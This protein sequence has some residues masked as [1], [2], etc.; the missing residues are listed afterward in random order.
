MQGLAGIIYPDIFQV[1]N[2]IQSMLRTQRHRSLKDQE[3]F[4]HKN[5][6]IGLCGGKIVSNEKK[7]IFSGIDGTITNSLEIQL[8]LR[9]KGI[10]LNDTS[11]A[12]IVLKSYEC[13][14]VK[15]FDKLDGDFA[16]MI[17]DT[18]E[19]RLILARDRIGKKPLYWFQNQNS[20]M[21][22]SELKALL[23][24]GLVP[25]TPAFD[26]LASY[27]YF[28]YIPQD[29]SPIEGVSKLLPAHYLQFE[30]NG[31]KSIH[32][33]WSY[34][35][36]FEKT[37]TE[38]TEDILYNL[39]ALL[40]ES[41]KKNMTTADRMGCFIS[42][43][44]G[45]AT[46]A[47][48]MKQLA[49][50]DQI[51]TYSVGFQGEY[52][53]DLL[54][55]K[56]V[57]ATLDLSNHSYAIPQ[58]EFLNDLCKI[59]WYLDEPLADPNIISTWKLAAMASKETHTTFSGMGS[60]ELFAGHS[61]YTIEE[62][63]A[64]PLRKLFQPPLS[65]MR[66]ALIPLLQRLYK[67]FA[68]HLIKES[69]TDPWQFGYLRQNAL[70]NEHELHKISPKLGLIFDPGVFL[71]KFNHLHRIQS[72]V[73]SYLYFDVKTRLADCYVL[74][75]DRL[76]AAHGIDWKAPYL[77]RRLVEYL[78]SLPEPD[79]LQEKRTAT[80]LKSLMKNTLPAS[81]IDRPKRTRK[82]FL[83]NWIESNEVKPLFDLL[84]HGTLIDTG[85]ISGVWLKEHINRLGKGED[86]HKKLWAVLVLEIWFRLYINRSIGT[87]PPRLSVIDLLKE[88]A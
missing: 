32:S 31:S 78:A 60:D 22:A 58:N 55:A 82:S 81:M 86:A 41:V 39:D 56:D 43:G 40:L 35:S 3:V 50:A 7:T 88:P 38:K 85:L 66:K 24:T 57:A 63:G 59:I 47:Y 10:A 16:L 30:F 53:Q 36:Y 14:G 13:Y 5:I 20:F 84:M 6:Q 51:T 12:G 28:G 4:T 67:P 65:H 54:I 72:K 80:F 29:M 44:I 83:K 75:F 76:T 19:Q 27:L 61:R 52:D 37:T 87:E 18:H 33:Y 74:Q 73:A 17:L 48:Y 70:I 1:T 34:S 45:S 62:Q 68:Y 26:A 25:Q 2:L 77:D 23:A 69:R 49:T 46:I 21:F 42:G 8:G 15:C 71:H 11:D 64:H 79:A 9:E